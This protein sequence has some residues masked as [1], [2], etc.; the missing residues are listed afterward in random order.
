[1]YELRFIEKK[2]YTIRFRKQAQ[3][4]NNFDRITINVSVDTD[5]LL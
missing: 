4:I 5:P 3:E 2:N 1:M